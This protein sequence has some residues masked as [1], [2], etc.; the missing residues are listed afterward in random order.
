MRYIA[1]VDVKEDFSSVAVFTRGWKGAELAGGGL[2]RGGF[3]DA[4]REAAH[5]VKEKIY[6]ISPEKPFIILLVPRRLVHVTTVEIP[7]RNETFLEKMMKFEVARHFP[8]PSEQLVHDFMLA[9][10][11]TGGF[12][13]NLAGLKRTDFNAY[14]DAAREA[15]IAPDEVSFS[16]AAWILP[17]VPD[18]EITKRIFVEVLPEGFEM[19]VL[20][21]ARLLYSRFNLFKPKLEEKYFH[22]RNVLGSSSARGIADKI[23]AEL[24]QI[25][26]VSGIEH[27]SE[28]LK[29]LFIAGGG[30]MRKDIGRRLAEMP[31]FADS[32]ISYLP[33]G[34]DETGFDYVAAVTG[35]EVM[36][37][38]SQRFNF[39]PADMRTGDGRKATRRFTVS[40]TMAVLAVLW[41][42]ST[43]LSQWKTATDLKREL[44]NLKSKAGG[45]EEVDLRIEEYQSYFES[46]KKFSATPSF[47]MDLLEG[48]TNVLPRD[49][50]LV[51]ME[52]HGGV[53]TVSGLSK[54]ASSLLKIM[55]ADQ[56]FKSVRMAGAVKTVGKNEK[57]KIR[58]ELE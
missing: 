7:A 16:S 28:Y 9:G 33:A 34:D 21:G 32:F 58:M 43:Y 20:D 49:S 53:I 14:F 38:K 39:I 18:D 26:L 5:K 25:R 35:A 13:V 48:I 45:V 15:G 57:F 46:F 24:N 2:V 10:R 40:I 23:L 1:V 8:V 41:I 37:K 6:R 30:A 11:V 12:A 17:D 3:A 47:T 51:D 42:A 56:H 36:D 55:E 50:F 4:V 31:E 52:I 44:A 54:D 22:K 27:L 19:S 29:K